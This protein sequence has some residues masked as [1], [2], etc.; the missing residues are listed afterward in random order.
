[1]IKQD[2]TFKSSKNGS[3]ICQSRDFFM[4]GQKI[5]AASVPLGKFTLNISLVG[6]YLTRMTVT[7]ARAS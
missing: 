6:S 3:Y 2:P 7:A 1:M 4:E 5:L